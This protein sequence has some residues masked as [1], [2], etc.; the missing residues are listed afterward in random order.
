L[1]PI[2]LTCLY[3]APVIQCSP[4]SVSNSG[5][6]VITSARSLC[7]SKPKSTPIQR[8][9]GMHGSSHFSNLTNPHIRQ[10]NRSTRSSIGSNL[11]VNWRH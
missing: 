11:R 9:R 10:A 4:R 2:R 6:S 1:M 3:N 7:L 8:L 5:T